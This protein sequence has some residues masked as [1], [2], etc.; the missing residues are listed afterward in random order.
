MKGGAREKT[1][2]LGALAEYQ[3]LIPSIH[4]MVHIV[5]GSSSEGLILSFALCGHSACKRCT[6][7]HADKITP[8]PWAPATQPEDDLCSILQTHKVEGEKLRQ[9]AVSESHTH[10]TAHTRLYT[11]T[12]SE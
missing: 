3:G 12:L 5:F 11:Y 8:T 7:T 9:Q 4:M 2:W 1:Q 6:Y 10:V